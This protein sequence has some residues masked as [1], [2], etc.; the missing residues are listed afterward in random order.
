VALSVKTP[1]RGPPRPLAGTL[2]CGDRTFLPLARAAI[3]PAP[4]SVQSLMTYDVN[5]TAADFEKLSDD[6]NLHELDEGELVVMPP[7]GFRHGIAQAAVLEALSGA[8]ESGIALGRCGFRL[9]PDVVYAPDAAFISEKRR[10]GMTWDR[11]SDFGPDLAV[12]VLS[13]D[14]N[15]ARLQRRSD[16]TRRVPASCGFWTPNPSPSTSTRSQAYSE[17]WPP[18][19]GSTRPNCFRASRSRCGRCLNK[20]MLKSFLGQAG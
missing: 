10:S 1:L 4:A 18:T 2:P 5:L 7:P 9:A 6:D 14:D 3:R 15:A 8:V 11:Y 17:H 16:I 13:P 12:E 20:P 19:T